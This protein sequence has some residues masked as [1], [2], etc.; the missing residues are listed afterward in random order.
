V[1]K[2]LQSFSSPQLQTNA[3]AGVRKGTRVTSRAYTGGDLRES[4]RERYRN[5]SLAE[6]NAKDRRIAAA[7]VR[8]WRKKGLL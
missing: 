5:L 2:L 6:R 7:T 1:C 3:A 4:R 8:R